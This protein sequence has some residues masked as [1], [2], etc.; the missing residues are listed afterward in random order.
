MI[1]RHNLKDGDY[2]RRSR[3]CQWFLHQCNNRRFLA[4]FVIGDEAGFALNGAVNNHNVQM[5]APANQAPD[6]H[7]NANDS[8]QKLTVWVGLF[9]NGDMLG[10]FYFD[11][12]VNGQNYLNLLNDKATPLMT[13]LFQNE[14]HENRFQRLWWA[15]DEAPCHG[16]LVVRGRLNQLSGERV[17]SLHNNSEWPPRSPKY[18]RPYCI[19]YI[20]SC[21]N[22]S[23]FTR[24]SSNLIILH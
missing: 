6:F 20:T 24:V 15:H 11:G 14:F 2:E 23:A 22:Y 8:G 19:I 7:Y 13:V 17:L 4:N 12:N 10:P 1:R 16:L 21:H 3:F 5:Y 18:V 9:G